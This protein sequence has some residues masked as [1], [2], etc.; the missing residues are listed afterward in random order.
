MSQI[1]WHLMYVHATRHVL[2]ICTTWGARPCFIC[3]K[4]TGTCFM[5]AASSRL[6]TNFSALLAAAGHPCPISLLSQWVTPSHPMKQ[7]CPVSGCMSNSLQSAQTLSWSIFISLLQECLA[8]DHALDYACPW[9][10][11]ALVSINDFPSPVSALG[12]IQPCLQYAL[13]E[14]I[15]NGL[16]VV[17]GYLNRLDAISRLCLVKLWSKELYAGGQASLDEPPSKLTGVMPFPISWPDIVPIWRKAHE[18][19]GQ[20]EAIPGDAAEIL[21][22]ATA[23]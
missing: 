19:H 5:L 18:R 21:R 15:A 16:E 17:F 11:F 12:M 6:G 9:I 14:D 13:L 2:W 3:T 23:W 7:S 4:L 22:E 10:T 8:P 20:A 1:A